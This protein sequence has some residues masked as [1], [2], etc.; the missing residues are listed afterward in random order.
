MSDPTQSTP[1]GAAVVAASEILPAE[2][3]T[4]TAPLSPEQQTQGPAAPAP[5]VDSNAERDAKGVPFDP[6]RHLARKHPATGRWMPKGGRKPGSGSA[7]TSSESSAGAP[8]NPL[9]PPSASFIPDAAPPPPV[10]AKAGSDEPAPVRV[11][12]V[13]HS[14]DA[15]ECGVCAVVAVAGLVFDEDCSPG[16]AEEKNMKKAV[17]AYIRAKGWQATAGIG[18]FLMFAAY[19]LRLLRKPGPK[20]KVR[21]WFR[22]KGAKSVTPAPQSGEQS[23]EPARGTGPVI[24]IPAHI[25][26]LAR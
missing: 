19:V 17:A 8:S 5:L 7:P 10:E 6:A 16:A 20:T 11:E 25:P 1:S 21:E 12:S 23:P 15:A 18:L 24:D 2:I 13:D 22:F 4:P 3:P 26:P 14:D 9:P